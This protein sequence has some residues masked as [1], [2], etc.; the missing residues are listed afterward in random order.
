[1]SESHLEAVCDR[2]A[3]EFNI[4]LDVGE[5]K[6]IYLEAIRKPAEAEGKYIRQTGG[7]GNYGHV[8]IRLEANEAGRGFEFIDNIK[9]NKF[10]RKYIAPIEQGIHEAIQGGVLFGYEIADVKVTLLDGSYHDVDS[11]EMAF[12][13]AGSLAFKEAARKGSPVL[14]EPVMAAEA[15][16]PEVHIGAIL[17]DINLRRGR[18]EGIENRAGSMAVKAMIPLHETLRFSRNGRFEYPMQFARYELAPPRF[19]GFGDD[20]AGV[21]VKNPRHPHTG[22]GFA[23]AEQ[24]FDSE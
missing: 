1:M 21:I 3:H 4:Q 11:N 6:V 16:I 14:L 20:G 17:S 10:P 2:I 8:K 18:I 12:K 5:P 23:A 24:S 13:I 22:S 19:G 7:S 15:V 9:S